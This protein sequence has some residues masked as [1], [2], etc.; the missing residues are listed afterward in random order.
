MTDYDAFK[1]RYK[2]NII[3]KIRQPK[4][5]TNFFQSAQQTEKWSAMG[6]N[7]FFCLIFC[8]YFVTR[9]D[10]ANN[11]LRTK[12]NTKLIIQLQDRMKVK[13]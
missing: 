13:I 3:M 9:T 11:F 5:I 7:V 6:K 10:S 4:M 2:E 1:Y 8:T 12:L